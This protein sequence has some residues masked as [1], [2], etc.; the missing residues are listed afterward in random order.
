MH[1]LCLSFL[2]FFTYEITNSCPPSLSL[3]PTPSLSQFILMGFIGM[4]KIYLIIINKRKQSFRN[5]QSEKFFLY[6]YI[7]GYVQC[8]SS[9]YP[10]LCLSL[11]LPLFL[12]GDFPCCGH[13]KTVLQSIHKKQEKSGL[14]RQKDYFNVANSITFFLSL[15]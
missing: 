5:K 9:L 6:I 8:C 3:S 1:L 14:G 10:P 7:V 2:L 4:G 11:P 15:F 13:W 12:P